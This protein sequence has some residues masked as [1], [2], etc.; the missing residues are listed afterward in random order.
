[1]IPTTQP[2]SGASERRPSRGDESGTTPGQTTT[3]QTTT[4]ETTTE[5]TTTTETTRVEPPTPAP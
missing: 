2:T 4:G 5:Q 3:G 1:M